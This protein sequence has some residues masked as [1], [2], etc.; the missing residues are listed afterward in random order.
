MPKT[1]KMR[2]IRLTAPGQRLVE[3]IIDRP[4]SGANDVVIKIEA[5]GICHSDVHYR[6]G[7][8]TTGPVP[9][10]LG[11]EISGTVA[12]TGSGVD[13]LNIGD[14]VCVH[15]LAYCGSCKYCRQGNEQ[16]CE[17]GAMIGK[18][19]DGGYGEY[20]VVPALSVLPLPDS[21]RFEVGAVLMCS[22]STAYHALRK[23]RLKAG[24]AVAIF[25]IG[26]LGSAGVQLAR[27]MGAAE[28]Y[29]VDINPVKLELAARHGAIPVDAAKADPVAALKNVTGGKG[30]NVAVE[31]I[32][33][34]LTIEQA[35]RCLAPLGRAVVAGITHDNIE[36]G[37]YADLITGER[38]LIGVSD[39]LRVE[40]EQLLNW[41]VEGKLDL[42]DII[43]GTVPLDADAINQ[44][45]DQL[46][47][48][49][50]DVRVVVVPPA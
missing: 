22:W 18:D 39:H 28:V 27:M 24:E 50:D 31:L 17:S 13:G 26:G 43:T 2:A 35:L 11:H 16:F 36:I 3:Q 1:Q 7:G 40:L 34:P 30:V 41:A 47:S 48:F 5:A 8:S 6:G 44:I 10:T 14:R 32:G 45:L 37:P 23:S 42:Q 15:Y 21:V 4:Q 19:R 9:I 20:V 46:E 25:G 33:L 12:E 29:A 38:E 49:S